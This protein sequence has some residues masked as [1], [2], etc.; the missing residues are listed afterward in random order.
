[1][2][3]IPS[4]YRNN[5]SDAERYIFSLLRKIELAPGWTAFHS[6]NVSE[7]Q[8]KEW[9]ELD[10]VILGPKGVFVLEVKGGG[11][12]CRD[13]IWYFTDRFGI[14]HQNSEGPF[15]Q[16]KKGMYA[17]KDR[18]KKSTISHNIDNVCFGWGVVFPNVSWENYGAEMPKEVICD[19]RMSMN[20]ESFKKYLTGLF[21]YWHNKKEYYQELDANSQVLKKIGEFL[22]PNFDLTPSLSS[23]LNSIHK[24]IVRH[25]EEQ[26]NYIDSISAAN[27]I[28]CSGGAGT[29]KS[30]LAIETANRELFDKK[31][32][33]LVTFHDIFASFLK[34]Q[35]ANL[36][37]TICSLEE[38]KSSLALFSKNPF[39]VLVVDEGQDIMTIENLDI[40]DRVIKNGLQDGRWR[41]F[42]DENAQANVMGSFD[43][44]ALDIL[45]SYRPTQQ[46]LKH[47]CRNTSQIIYETESV[48]GARIGEAFTRNSGVKVIY[49]KIKNTEDQLDKV[50]HQIEKWYQEDDVSLSDIVI[51]SPVEMDSSVVAHFP[52]KW[53]SR[54]QS[55]TKDNIM[56]AGE[57]FM[58]FSSIPLFKGLERKCVLLVDMEH[59]DSSDKAKSLLYVAYTRAHAVLW[60]ALNDTF[61]NIVNEFKVNTY[62][63]KHE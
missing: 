16:A 57:N 20:S 19:E 22:R 9:A 42:M 24:D 39:D 1:L 31:T 58:L 60:I 26:Y 54:I 59:I 17:L 63:S 62:E 48:T 56:N 61:D 34:N 52:K 27:Q 21:G 44:D 40:F 14:K 33:L 12:T 45:K 43:A 46:I 15:N 55:I 11:V 35:I 30:F 47:N 6:L 25:T 8:Y 37:L 7:H 18:L 51:L 5:N 53:R 50:I 29:G 4:I 49:S 28:I 3:L 41:F 13:G 23:Q 2:K 10:F 32:V 36:E 38:L